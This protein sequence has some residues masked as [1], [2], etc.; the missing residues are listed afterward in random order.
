ML[1][2]KNVKQDYN[3]KVN[4]KSFKNVLKVK[5]L[6]TPDTYRNCVQ[7]KINSRLKS[8]VLSTIEAIFLY[9]T[10]ETIPEQPL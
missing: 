8:G 10:L 9:S 7:K 1:R 5:Y 6:G 3:A 4:N 2:H